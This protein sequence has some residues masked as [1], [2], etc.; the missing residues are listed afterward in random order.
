MS[1]KCEKVHESPLRPARS[2]EAYLL[3]QA[4]LE[5]SLAD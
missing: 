1:W 5:W 4:A 2:E 3:H